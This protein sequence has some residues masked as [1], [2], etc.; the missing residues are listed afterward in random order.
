MTGGRS[1]GAVLGVILLMMVVIPTTQVSAETLTLTIQPSIEDM[2]FQNK[3]GADYY[4][5]QETSTWD[6]IH[7]AM[8]WIYCWS[9]DSLIEFDL[10]SINIPAEKIIS[11]ELHMYQYHSGSHSNNGVWVFDFDA[12][13]YPNLEPWD[14]G[15]AWYYNQPAYD[16]SYTN[17]ILITK[18]LG[19]RIW[20]VTEIVQDWQNGI[21]PNYGLRI[22]T[23]D[24]PLASEDSGAAFYSSETGGE[25][26]PK[27]VI[28]YEVPIDITEAQY[29]YV[30]DLL[31][32]KATSELGAADPLEVVG[33]GPMFWNANKGVWE[34]EVAE[35]TSPPAMITVCGTYGCGTIQ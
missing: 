9:V 17:K 28:H 33:Y 1:I 27:L 16:S 26:T 31:S 15:T 24:N 35:V 34:L 21:I 22:F 7:L 8:A 18:D 2:S 4:G 23:I 20:D 14:R 10:T 6:S 30:N 11:A 5:S 12:E 19:W 13:V 29:D 25:L 3:C 32:V